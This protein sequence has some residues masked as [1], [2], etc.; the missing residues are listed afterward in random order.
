MK[1]LRPHV[2]KRFQRLSDLIM[3]TK[4]K[5]NA[6]LQTYGY[7]ALVEDGIRLLPIETLSGNEMDYNLTFD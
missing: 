1:T 2:V 4:E 5:A 6:F 3:H 7:L